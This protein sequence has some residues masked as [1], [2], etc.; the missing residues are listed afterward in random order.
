VSDL[1]LDPRQAEFFTLYFRR[2]PYRHPAPLESVSI[3]TRGFSW[4]TV[5]APASSYAV[6]QRCRDRRGFTLMPSYTDIMTIVATLGSPPRPG[7]C[8]FLGYGGS[9]LFSPPR[10]TAP[11][12]FW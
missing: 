10:L 11:D 3:P 12:T 9:G 7:L 6:S 8:Q 5:D 4:T 2:F 1:D